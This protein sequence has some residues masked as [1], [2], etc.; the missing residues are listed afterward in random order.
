MQVPPDE[1]PAEVLPA[2]LSGTTTDA[3]T[4]RPGAGDDMTRVRLTTSDRAVRP[5]TLALIAAAAAILAKSK[6][7]MTLRQLHYQLVARQVTPNT[8]GAYKSL[9]KALAWARVHGVVG[10]DA[11]EDRLRVPRAVP[12]WR[13]LADF[14]DAVLR[15]YRRDVWSQQPELVEVWLEKDALSS[16]VGDVL[17]PYGATLNVGRGYDG[18]S[19]LHAAAI[20]YR[21]AAEAG[22]P[23]TVL[24]LGDHDPSGQD[25]VASLAGRLSEMGADPTIERVAILPEDI[26]RYQLPPDFTKTTDTRRAAFVAKHGDRAVELDSLPVDALV[27]R[28]GAAI[29]AHLDQAAFLAVQEAEAAD[30]GRITETVALLTDDD[31]GDEE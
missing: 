9:S 29:V 23:V 3:G 17:E 18:W 30:Q 20:R 27:A 7:A 24:Y 13:D 31:D 5:A 21:H 28:L 10:W 6:T 2:E 8:R 16:I 19:S 14:A 11:I 22:R 25:M 4:L 15:S 26:D 1:R 12:Q